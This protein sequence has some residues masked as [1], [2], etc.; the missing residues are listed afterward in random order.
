MSEVAGKGGSVTF[1][2][3]QTSIKSWN[4]P[5]WTA[6]LE[7]ITDFSDGSAGYKKYAATLTDWTAT[8]ELNW[9]AANTATPGSSATLTLN[10]DDSNNYSGSAIL[11]TISVNEPVGGIVTATATFQ[12]N[13]LLTLT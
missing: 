10:V 4:I 9:D 5:G 3:F 11:Q 1:T 13:G 7:E 6:D 8:V 12:G 2:N